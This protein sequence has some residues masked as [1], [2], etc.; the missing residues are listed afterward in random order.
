MASVVGIAHSAYG[1]LETIV[2]YRKILAA[3]TGIEIAKRYSGSAFGKVWV[4]LYPALLLATYL[5]VYMVI[6]RMRIPEYSQ[7]DYVLYVFCGLVPFLSLSEAV[8]T[9]CMALKQNLHL[10]KNVMLPIELIPVRTILV[11]MVTQAVSLG[12]LLVLL[13]CNGSLSFHLAWLPLVILLQF[14]MVLGLV[15]VLSLLTLLL[16]DIAYVVNLLLLLLMF[17]SPIGFTPDKVPAKLSF[18]VYLNPIHYLIDLYR[19]SLLWGRFPSFLGATVC[20]LF[21]LVIFALGSALFRAFKNVVAD[22]E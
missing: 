17:L 12:I 2:R 6:F 19:C 20:V 14:L 7:F 22:S 8:T 16:P 1:M 5:F 15:L 13:A 10:V 18:V 11:S 9:G 21:C 4:V 3:V